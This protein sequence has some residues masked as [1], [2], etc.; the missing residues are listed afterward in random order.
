[1]GYGHIAIVFLIF[2]MIIY[3]VYRWLLKKIKLEA[4]SAGVEGFKSIPYPE[5]DAFKNMQ[6]LPLKE[7]TIKASFNSA[8]DGKSI[9]QDQ[10]ANVMYY[11]C[12]FIDVN[13][14]VVDSSSLYVGFSSDNAPTMVD[15]SL[16]FHK[17]IDYINAYGFQIDTEAQG[18]VS[19][20]T[21]AVQKVITPGTKNQK[22]IQKTYTEYPLFLNIRVYRPPSSNR[23]IISLIYDELKKLKKPHLDPE[24]GSAAK[25]SQY[26]PL[27]E[28]MGKVVVSMDIENILQVYTSPAPY[29]PE[30]IST[31]TREMIERM[32]NLKTG[33]QN[34]GTFYSYAD[35][36]K[37][38][39][40]PLMKLSDDVVNISYET[41]PLMMKLAYPSYSEKT[42]IPD[43]LD[44]LLN[45]QI[46]IVPMRYYIA[47]TNLDAYNRMFDTNKTPFLPLYNAHTYLTDKRNVRK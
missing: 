36:V 5:S 17:V 32:V 31:D 13:V 38:T 33:G 16:P 39:Q 1:M 19:D 3:L 30:K 14:F 11:G 41:N 20:Y 23:N 42:E 24:T 27:S 6:N 7:Y 46:Q 29:D 15:V 12:R 9:T 34:C 2:F 10:L 35:V 47:G 28:I 26:T 4:D 37:N 22:T 21:S 45:Y 18:R 40:T 44:F 25:I 8:Y 43:A